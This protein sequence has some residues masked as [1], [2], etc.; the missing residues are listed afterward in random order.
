MINW[1]KI[2]QEKKYKSNNRKP[3]YSM[4]KLSI[5][6]VSCLLGFSILFGPISTEKSILNSSVVLASNQLGLG[7]TGPAVESE[8]KQDFYY[9][10]VGK[11]YRGNIEDGISTRVK[12]M[13]IYG[14]PYVEF[15]H[16]FNTNFVNRNYHQFFFSVPQSLGTPENWVIKQYNKQ[17][18]LIQEMNDFPNQSSDTPETAGNISG[19]KIGTGRFII[20]DKDQGNGVTGLINDANLF[21]KAIDKKLVSREVIEPVLES[22]Q[23]N[24]YVIRSNR[25]T[26]ANSYW[27]VSYRAK[28]IDESSSIGYIA[29]SSILSA[30]IG[31]YKELLIGIQGEVTV[32]TLRNEQE[33]LK[34]LEI[35]DI[36]NIEINENQNGTANVIANKSILLEDSNIKI[37]NDN[38]LNGLSAT[39]SDT[40]ISTKK[41][42][43]FTPSIDDW[44]NDEIQREFNIEVDINSAVRGDDLVAKKNFKVIVK[45]NHTPDV[46]ASGPG[47]EKPRGYH[48]VTLLTGQN[49]ELVNPGAT[50]VFYVKN[51]QALKDENLPKLR[52]K[53]GYKDARWPE[54]AKESVENDKT[55]SAVADKDNLSDN[56]EVTANEVSSKF[57]EELEEQKVKD[58]IQIV[59]TETK[60]QVQISVDKNGFNPRLEGKQTVKATVTFSDKTIK[61]VEV[62]V[63][64]GK[65]PLNEKYAPTAEA[66][67]KA[68]GE[69]LTEEDVKQA[70]KFTPEYDGDYKVEFDG[71]NKNQ[72]GP[73]EIQVTVKYPDGTEDQVTVT[74]N[75]G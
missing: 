27:K 61:E 33:K 72:E 25:S 45:R 1:N 17:H 43:I 65:Q 30:G 49:T 46:I 66:I 48:T 34:P 23:Q 7:Y 41:Q 31:D 16:T 60:D 3:K 12:A 8:V 42:I 2:I 26:N 15:E 4:K 58:A 59:G 40:E 69:D 36:Q 29:G 55:I 44:K 38:Q 51:G 22:S 71:F 6:F 50:T 57:G 53:E 10:F 64:V 20:K 47:I 11:D 5:G 68:Y 62:T 54:E 74:V 56:H 32:K 73:Q 13:N 18:D 63:N 35:D 52:A 9:A 19:N 21:E 37:T 24:Y 14:Q 70:I 28:I 67:E 75:V 39:V